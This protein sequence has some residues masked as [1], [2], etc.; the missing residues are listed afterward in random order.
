[1]EDNKTVNNEGENNKVNEQPKEQPANNAAPEPAGTEPK[2]TLITKAKKHWKGLTAA[3][4]GLV[5][6]VLS[7][8]AA[9]KRGKAASATYEPEQPGEDY[10]LN[11]NN[12]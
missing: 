12:E 11:P 8:R 1:M 7:A 3:G 6:I 4:I 10:T 5:G 2:E 9:Y